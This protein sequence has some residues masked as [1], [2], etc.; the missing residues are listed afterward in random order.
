MH[1]TQGLPVPPP[2]FDPDH[3]D[4]ASSASS[5][6]DT[7][8]L[9]TCRPTGQGAGSKDRSSV[10]ATAKQQ[11]SSPDGGGLAAT[12][13]EQSGP[14]ALQ[15]EAGVYQR[16]AGAGHPT[17]AER[18]CLAPAPA[19]C[20]VGALGSSPFSAPPAAT[21]LLPAPGPVQLPLP[22]P[23]PLPPL[24]GGRAQREVELRLRQLVC[25]P[26]VGAGPGAQDVGPTSPTGA[27]GGV[28]AG[29]GAGPHAALGA[30]P[31]PSSPAAPAVLLPVSSWPQGQPAAVALVSP[32]APNSLGRS[33]TLGPG[34]SAEAVAAKGA[35][36]QV[37][38]GSQGRFAAAA[39]A[40][41]A[42]D[43]LVGRS[44]RP[45]VYAL[46]MRPTA[47]PT[48]KPPPPA[49][50]QPASLAAEV[51]AAQCSGGPG[52]APR[53]ADAG[54][55]S[56]S[57]QGS[58]QRAEQVESSGCS[59]GDRSIGHSGKSVGCGVGGE[60]AGGHAGTPVL[61]AA[62][63]QGSTPEGSPAVRGALV[64]GGSG[65][66]ATGAVGDAGGTAAVALAAG[67]GGPPLLQHGA[68]CEPAS[69]AVPSSDTPG[70]FGAVMDY[71]GA[72]TSGPAATWPMGLAF[73]P[74][75]RPLE[76]WPGS[77]HVQHGDGHHGDPQPGPAA[78]EAEAAAGLDVPAGVAPAGGA[79]AQPRA[80][81]PK[82]PDLR[83][84]LL[85]QQH[86]S[87]QHPPVLSVG[88]WAGQVPSGPALDALPSSAA[89]GVASPPGATPVPPSPFRS[90]A[91][92]PPLSHATPGTAG[93]GAAQDLGSY[94]SPFCP[95]A[96]TLRTQGAT[97]AH[98]QH[99]AGGDT[100]HADDTPG[101]G[102]GG[103]G[104]GVS[105][106]TTP[107]QNSPYATASHPL[108]RVVMASR[109]GVQYNGSEHDSYL[110]GDGSAY[111]EPYDNPAFVSTAQM[112]CSPEQQQQQPAAMQSAG[113]KSTRTQREL[114]RPED[115]VLHRVGPWGNARTS[116][117]SS[118]PPLTE[119]VVKRLSGG[120]GDVYEPEGTGAG[121]GAAGEETLTAE[122]QRLL[123]G[124]EGPEAQDAVRCGVPMTPQR[125][126]PTGAARLH[127]PVARQVAERLMTHNPLYAPGV[128]AVATTEVER[129]GGI[130]QLQ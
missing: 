21:V 10:A 62:V 55:G 36:L 7:R 52:Q 123:A 106:L 19:G 22:G 63:L 5:C 4:S 120:Y 114:S 128:G 111:H 97:P 47:A 124:E 112:E 35:G 46:V 104:G 40:V 84:Q 41:S 16:G 110:L 13:R 90:P 86:D 27:A 39:V 108:S 43:L 119:V 87:A 8:Q 66:P 74:A 117:R 126:S 75:L 11:L 15:A 130:A 88:G 2:A 118:S 54:G 61:G 82:Q 60:R 6:L 99:S 85:Q 93:D 79:G 71:A 125:L 73:V 1:T 102:G 44:R 105:G 91:P 51:T 34:P 107:N 96:H 64:D 72:V 57:G 113:D 95:P 76:P 3:R 115:L 9:D 58:C 129:G 94:R 100:N 24:F 33:T 50:P 89:S 48:L 78:T 20:E 38:H 17:L 23:G 122:L 83:Y 28:P 121:K 69:A 101:G 116:A 12:F 81:V 37:G 67:D 98:S 14:A 59:G 30:Q 70:G 127:G 92:L 65:E 53:E 32:S 42:A 31:P 26:A 29:S 80:G 25:R 49:S 77:Q 56:G 109:L 45:L 103:G 18:A 68:A